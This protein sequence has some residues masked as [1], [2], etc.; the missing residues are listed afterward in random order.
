MLIFTAANGSVILLHNYCHLYPKTYPSQVVWAI[1][2]INCTIHCNLVTK[3]IQY[4]IL[5]SISNQVLP[6]SFYI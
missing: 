3:S 1:K 6:P 2:N 5:I 4:T